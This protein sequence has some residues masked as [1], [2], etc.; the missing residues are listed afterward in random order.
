MKRV[1]GIGGVFFKAKDPAKLK[2]WYD[3]HLDVGPKRD[4]PWGG[5][6]SATL[7][8]WRDFDNKE[9]VCTTVFEPFPDDTTY[10][11]PSTKP[12]MF[13]FRV[14]DLK[15]LLDQL[16]KEGVQV[17]DKIEELPYGRFGWII[18]PEGN[19][20]ELWEPAEGY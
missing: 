8:L 13:N 2:E 11:E 15:G 9:Q 7:L 18:D 3:K 16:R 1:T 4:G 20:I 10:F 12:F 19:R 5:E 6:D 17:E 14:A